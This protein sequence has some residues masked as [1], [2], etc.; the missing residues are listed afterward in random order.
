MHPAAPVTSNTVPT[1]S[2]GHTTQRARGGRQYLWMEYPFV[3]SEPKVCSEPKNEEEAHSKREIQGLVH[4]RAK[5]R[6]HARFGGLCFYFH[7][8]RH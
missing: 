2:T 4:F 6:A 7:F 1:H 3:Y 8:D 5:I